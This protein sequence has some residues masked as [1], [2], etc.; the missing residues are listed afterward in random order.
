M[1]P[2]HV[3]YYPNSDCQ[4]LSLAKA[5][6]VFDE[7]TFFDHPSI[8][9]AKVGTVGHPSGM[10]HPA[11]LLKEEG[12]QINIIEPKGGPIEGEL[13]S[14]IDADLDNDEYR[15][16]FF[17]LLRN[18]QSFLM[19]K[20]QNGNYGKYGDGEAYRQGLLGVTDAEVPRT[21]AD[22]RSF[23][24]VDG[25]PPAISIAMSMA[26]D[27]YKLNFSTYLAA[28]KG[29][30]LFGDSKGMDML[31][32]AKLKLAP[33]GAHGEGGISQQLAF[34]LLEHLIPNE[35]FRGKKLIDVVRFRNEMYKD[36]EKFKERV[37]E[38]SVEHQNLTGESREQKL[39]QVLYK[40]LLPEA[41]DYQYRL[42]ENWDKFFKDGTTAIISE[43][44]RLAALVVTV[45]PFSYPAAL[46]AGAAHV[47]AKLMPH[48][49]SYLKEKEALNR[50]NPYNYLMRF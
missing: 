25:I 13:E 10:R 43:S 6:L 4:P 21:S 34:T 22:I 42:A 20:G 26:A 15:Q 9:F 36:R 49:V 41:R 19:N 3:L 38:F 31:L 14:I 7:V 24:P 28:Q 1:E 2:F 48:L 23:D 37:M 50:R 27:S 30:H 11:H 35:A 46:L 33:P 8:N 44:D 12:Y 32:N 17:R 5:I 16:I 47:G 18:D 40:Q 29:I 39:K 45:L